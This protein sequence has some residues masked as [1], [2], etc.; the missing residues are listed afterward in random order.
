MHLAAM[1]GSATLLR[2]LS[3]D[4]P[5]LTNAREWLYGAT[6]LHLAMITGN[7]DNVSVLRSFHADESV[8]T[9]FEMDAKTLEQA[10]SDLSSAALFNEPK[11]HL[12]II[13]RIADGEQQLFQL[14][15]DWN[16]AVEWEALETPVDAYGSVRNKAKKLHEALYSICPKKTQ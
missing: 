12:E 3:H 11:A 4:F 14:E 15:K 1:Y 16:K 13:S 2:A 10:I 8:E 5:Q 9:F 7:K 6:P